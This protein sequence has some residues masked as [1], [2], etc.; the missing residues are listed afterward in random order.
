MNLAAITAQLRREIGLDLA[1]VPEPAIRRAVK[2][3]LES[4]GLAAAG[5]GYPERLA[6]D[7][8]EFAAL[9]DAVTVP[10]TWFFRDWEPF[11][12]LAGHLRNLRR[13]PGRALRILSLPCASGEEPYAIAMTLLDAGWEP[14]SFRI[15]AADV[16]R[17]VLAAARHAHYGRTAFREPAATTYTRFF[18]AAGAQRR[19]VKAVRDAVNFLELNVLDAAALRRLAPVDI[20]F[21]RNL[22]IYLHDD[23]RRQATANLDAVLAPGGL[24]F[25]GYAESRQIFFPAYAPVAHSRAYAAIK[26]LAGAPPPAAPAKQTKPDAAS[27]P[28]RPAPASSPAAKADISPLLA[29][30]WRLADAGSLT[31]AETLCRQ[32]LAAAPAAAD[33][34]CLLGILA[35]ARGETARARRAFTAALDLDPA[36]A[37]AQTHARLLRP[38]PESA[39]LGTPSPS[40]ASP[41]HA[42]PNPSPRGRVG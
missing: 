32:V 33:A 12:F 2:Q 23:A 4:L 11:V 26:P 10:E 37:E 21:C 24:L 16:S 8:D 34:H 29:E 40:S 19:P 3:R 14:G 18:E 31:A 35:L 5:D 42:R 39:P 30:A 22:L 17:H 9:V 28:L 15:D 7:P 36:H 25:L 13:R 1:S 6:L 38:S 27:A 20:V 41:N